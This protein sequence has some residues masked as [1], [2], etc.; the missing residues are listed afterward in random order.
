M[1]I[2]VLG[3]CYES[4]L[5]FFYA[6]HQGVAN[7]PYERQLQAFLEDFPSWTLF[8]IPHFQDLG[9]EATALF[10]NAEPLQRAWARE[11]NVI[12][13]KRHWQFSIVQEQIRRFKPDVLW[14][15][16]AD[17]YLG[18]FL[19]EIRDLC[20]HIVVWKA[21]PFSSNLDWSNVDCVISS[22]LPFVEEFR[23]LG[24][25][26]ELMLP[27]FEPRILDHLPKKSRDIEVSFIG[28][29]ST[30]MNGAYRQRLIM[31]THLQRH[32][33]L[34]IYALKHRWQ[35]R[36]W[37]LRNFLAQVYYA[38]FLLRL[39]LNAAVYGLEMFKI[40]HRSRITLN[41]HGA[42]AKGLAGNQRLFEATGAGALLLT[43][44]APNLTQLFE[45][46]K[47][48][49]T[50]SSKEE[51]VEKISFL[52]QHESELERIAVAGQQRTLKDHNAAKRAEEFL[53]IVGKLA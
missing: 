38:P 43:E 21:S 34:Q 23:K 29:L 10:V 5:R 15:D 51:A 48:V 42:A 19:R 45:P 22:H 47:E 39:R 11:N 8:V 37:P 27:C 13:H 31:L 36:P 44:A 6:G 52:L 17:R 12:F 30:G 41:I 26:S 33:P 25:R 7:L 9:F 35:R 28:G 24:L 53:S 2:L 1:K 40:M 50:Y 16:G 20:R 18:Y 49:V 46:D 32:V 4:Y 3:E 14:L